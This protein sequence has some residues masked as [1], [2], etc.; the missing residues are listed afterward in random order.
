MLTRLD[1]RPSESQ[2]F[3][4]QDEIARRAYEKWSARNRNPDA[5]VSDWLEAEAEVAVSTAFAEHS[6][7]AQTRIGHLLAHQEESERRLLAEHT[8][9]RILATSGS[10]G[11][12]APELL[13]SIGECFDWEVGALWVRDPDVDLLRCLEVWQLPG[14]EIPLFTE[15]ARQRTFP[16]GSGLPGRVWA[17]NAVVWIPDLTTETNL[18]RGPVA[19]SEQ[20]RCA[21]GFPLRDPNRLFGVLEF[22]S[23]DVRAPD[24]RLVEMVSTIERQISQFV[25]RREVERRLCIE[26]Y[27]R[28]IARRIQQGFLPTSMPRLAGFE[29]SGKA[30]LPNAVGGDCFDFI[31]LPA[32]GKDSI[33]VFVADAMGHGFAA[34]LLMSETRAYLRGIATTTADIGSL[35]GLVNRCVTKDEAAANFVTA[36][37][38]RLDAGSR[39]LQYVNAGHL[40]GHVLDARGDVKALLRSR[41]LPLG[42]GPSTRYPTSQITLE[43]GDLIVLMTDGVVEASSCQG[44]LFGSQ[45]ALQVVGENRNQTSGEIISRLFE[46]V[47]DFC[48]GRFQDDLTAV[49]IKVMAERD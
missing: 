4:G 1:G 48:Q 17:S 12:A 36:V 15:D 3:E 13:Q 34:A 42:I 40:S 8:V 2:S 41:G 29:I 14:V 27:D 49:V 24:E 32:D 43:P 7:Q 47:S 21:I 22:W 33:G 30:L 16:I 11:D 44:E 31:P 6:A 20:L 35:A 9:S 26:E 45:R 38:V 5:E 23:Q 39:L 19:A 46:A 25:E 28:R 18:P 37:L 10:L